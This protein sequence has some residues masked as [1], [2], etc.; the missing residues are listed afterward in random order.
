MSATARDL[1]RSALAPLS[2]EQ[3]D[4]AIPLLRQA[5]ALEPGSADAM[6]LLGTAL[7]A[8]GDVHEGVA[9]VETAAAAAPDAFL[10][11]LK[12]GELAIRLGDV[13]AA[14]S[15]L[16]AALRIA[17]PGSPDAA[18]ARALLADA[19]LRGRRAIPHHAVV[20]RFVGIGRLRAFLRLPVCT[21][22]TLPVADETQP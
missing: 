17:A 20:P 16:L 9:L 7:V 13:A 12:A 15:H 22:R 8:A 6:C 1:L 2:R 5:L 11:R 4:V 10:P 3:L 19:R 14:E 18:A 21:A